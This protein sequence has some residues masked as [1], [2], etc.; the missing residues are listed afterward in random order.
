MADTTHYQSPIRAILHYIIAVFI[1]TLYGARVC[2]LIDSLPT[3]VLFI[4]TATVFIFLYFA[5]LITRAVKHDEASLTKNVSLF[6]IVGVGFAGWYSLLYDFP[7]GSNVKVVFGMTLLGIVINLDLAISNA[8]HLSKNNINKHKMPEN[9]KPLAGQIGLGAMFLTVMMT[10][11]L[12]LVVTKDLL[13]LAEHTQY[14][15]DTADIDSIIKEFVY[16][17]GVVLAY[18]ALISVNGAALVSEQ[19]TRQTNAMTAAASGNFDERVSLSQTGELGVIAYYTN[20]MIAD[21]KNSYDEINRTRDATIVGLSTLAEARNNETGAHILRTQ[22]YVKALAD[23]LKRQPKYSSYLTEETI[24][25]LY[26]SAP[27]HDVGKVGIPDSILLKPG[28]LTDEE[29]SIMKTHAQ[30]GADALSITEKS[31]DGIAFL[32]FAR[33]IAATHHEKWDGSGY[34]R[35]LSGEEI[36][37]SGRLMAL[38]DVYDALISKRVYKPAFSHEKAKEIILEGRCTHFDPAVVDAF[39]ACEHAFVDIAQKYKDED[40]KA[41]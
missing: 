5:R 13:W 6:S 39:L 37:L 31:G 12:G 29:F 18:I 3:A 28:K 10:V 32:R 27:L 26:K 40:V 41:A 16:V 2:P 21:L 36:P 14:Q 23:V 35:G 1:F 24:D 17:A 8:R 7:L 22:H 25:L 30:L 20:K 4:Q 15:V 19:L 33:E 11:L 38:A 9:I 34:P